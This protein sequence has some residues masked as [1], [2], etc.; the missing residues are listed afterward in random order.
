VLQ[1]MTRRPARVAWVLSILAACTGVADPPASP[2]SRLPLDPGAV[3]VSGVSS[4]GAMAVQFHTAHSRLVQGAGILAAPP[5]FCAENEV[6]LA[7]GRC[8]K[9]D[10]IPVE[11]LL[12]HADDLARRGAIDPVEGMADDRVWLY[13]GTADPHVHAAVADALE[14]Y[15]RSRIREASAV[16]RIEQPGAGHNFPVAQDRA[17]A[18][19]ASEPPYLGS[20]GYAAAG[21]LLEHVYGPLAPPADTTRPASLV[22]FDQRPY[23]DSARSAGLAEQGWLYVPTA[24]RADGAPCRLHVVFHGCKQGVASVGD[25]FVRGAGYLEVAEANR[26][27]VLFPQVKPTLQPLN[28]LGCWDWWGYEGSDYATR[29][30]RQ[31]AAVRAMIDALIAGPGGADAPPR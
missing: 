7:L 9:G 17:A 1:R 16:Q 18:C 29:D 20:C 3:T 2:L 27:V 12:Q 5:Y 23:A 13:R 10:G 19:V 21:A 28:P 4:G 26:I 24:C 31:I 30:G 25:A 22:A 6:G 11:R 15:Y 8:M 14:R